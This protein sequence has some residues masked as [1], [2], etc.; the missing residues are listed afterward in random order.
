[1]ARPVDP[2]DGRAFLVTLTEASHHEYADDYEVQ[3][4]L[5]AEYAAILGLDQ[6][7]ALR[8]SLSALLEHAHSA[9]IEAASESGAGGSG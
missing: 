2:K 4:E 3:Q 1:M 6:L 5:E 8:T 9:R 7:S